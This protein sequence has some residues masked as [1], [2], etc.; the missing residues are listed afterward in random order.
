[1][2]HTVQLYP[3]SAYQARLPS[4]LLASAAGGAS[5]VTGDTRQDSGDPAKRPLLFFQIIRIFQNK[6]PCPSRSP[7]LWCQVLLGVVVLL[8]KL[9]SL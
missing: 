9:Q 5:W 6:S 8:G 1:M 7:V 2:Q 3:W 4:A